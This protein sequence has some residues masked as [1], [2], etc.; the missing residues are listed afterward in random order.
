MTLRRLNTPPL[1]DTPSQNTI[2]SVVYVGRQYAGKGIEPW[3]RIG[4]RVM[5]FGNIMFL[6]LLWR[7]KVIVKVQSLLKTCSV[8]SK[9][10]F[11]LT[12]EYSTLKFMMSLT[13]DNTIE[14]LNDLCLPSTQ[15]RTV[16]VL[17]GHPLLCP[18]GRDL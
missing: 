11:G 3:S 5:T 9:W 8:R 17:S 6:L 10:F 12:W 1:R 13:L 14:L 2:L 15:N 16:F 4:R 7:Q 18:E